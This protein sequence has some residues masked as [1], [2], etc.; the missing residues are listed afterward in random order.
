MCN[1]VKDKK[2]SMEVL[3]N[4]QNATL[5]NISAYIYLQYSK[6]LI[7]DRYLIIGE[8][9]STET[10]FKG[11]IVDKEKL[12]KNIS[13]KKLYTLKLILPKKAVNCVIQTDNSWQR[14]YDI[15]I[16]SISTV[17]N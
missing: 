12:Q 15:S 5:D 16:L 2:L 1:I 6:E 17:E 10:C 13:R 14:K 3:R 8:E 9:L 4:F 7:D 11:V